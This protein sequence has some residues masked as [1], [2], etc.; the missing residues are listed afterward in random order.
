M[1]AA[2]QAR[3]AEAA[4]GPVTVRPGQSE[5]P[6]RTTSSPR[7]ATS[8]TSGRASASSSGIAVIGVGSLRTSARQIFVLVMAPRPNR[9][10][11]VA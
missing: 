11:Q 8:I 1:S 7:T 2:S 6:R 4:P 3:R 10:E 9:D 5:I